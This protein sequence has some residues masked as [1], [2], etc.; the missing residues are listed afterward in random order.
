MPSE[1][2]AEFI[3]RASNDEPTWDLGDGL[4]VHDA[5][6]DD[7][8]ALRP[9]EAAELTTIFRQVRNRLLG[10]GRTPPRDAD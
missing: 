10:S 9:D 1:I 2:V 6:M 7:L 5:L 3:R 8:L 4:R